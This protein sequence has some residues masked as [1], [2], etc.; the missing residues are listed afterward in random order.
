MEK[1]HLLPQ[2]VDRSERTVFNIH[3][4]SGRG[5]IVGQIRL[6]RGDDNVDL[7]WVKETPEE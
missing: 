3:E 7:E 6:K 1:L 4:N 5:P 2:F